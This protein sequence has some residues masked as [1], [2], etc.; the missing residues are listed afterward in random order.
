MSET[1]KPSGNWVEQAVAKIPADKLPKPEPEFDVDVSAAEPEAKAEAKPEPKVEAKDDDDG[2]ETETLVDIRALRAE[3]GKRKEA[4]R[5]A[6]EK[7]IEF[8]KAQERLE[9]IQ[10]AW[11][12]Q[13]QQAQQ[14]VAQQQAQAP[15]RDTDPLGYLE[16]QLQLEREARQQLEQQYQQQTQVSQQ[17]RVVQQVETAYKQAA[18]QFESKAPDFKQAY[19]YLYKQLDRETEL[20]GVADPTMRRNM[21]L[22]NEIRFAA[23]QLQG[24]RNPAEAIYEMARLRGYSPNAAAPAQNGVEL[25]NRR[26]QAMSPL[27]QAAGKSPSNVTLKDIVNLPMDEFMAKTS[28]KNWSKLLKG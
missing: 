4:E 6:R 25:Q 27:S 17:H 15:D 8:A 10:R 23:T 24:G 13:Q 14:P 9:M 26:Q 5:S 18:Q 19:D 20:S 1:E 11:E 21:L 22:N 3:R 2:D 7:E 12:S 28:G 16:H